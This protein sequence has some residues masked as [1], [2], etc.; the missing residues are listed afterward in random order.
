MKK[1]KRYCAFKRWLLAKRG[2]VQRANEYEKIVEYMEYC[3]RDMA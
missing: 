3:L 2:D 1:E